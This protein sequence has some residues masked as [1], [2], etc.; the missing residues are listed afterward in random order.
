M[1]EANKVDGADGAKP[2]LLGPSVDGRQV[3]LAVPSQKIQ[4]QSRRHWLDR[5]ADKVLGAEAGGQE[6][7]AEQRYALIC[8]ICFT[9]NGLC[10]KEEWEEVRECHD[11]SQ[12]ESVPRN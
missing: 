5:V 10:P 4:T 8:R 11:Y 6:V 9:H 12:K 2:A 1:R 7:K 3:Q